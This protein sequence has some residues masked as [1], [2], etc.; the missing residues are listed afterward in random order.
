MTSLLKRI[1]DLIS[2]NLHAMI[3]QAEDPEKMV[4]EYL[5]QLQ[6]QLYEARTTVAAAMADEDK[7]HR[8]WTSNQALADEWQAK[9]EAALRAGKEDLAKQAL[10]R[11]R[12]FQQIADSYKAQYEAQD[13]QVEELQEAL[14]KLEARIAEARTRREII[15]AKKHQAETQEA[16]YRTVRTLGDSTTA[17]EG[18]ATMEER[19]DERLAR[20]R[21][22]AQ[23]QGGVAEAQLED[24]EAEAA[25]AEDLAE[26][27]KKLGLA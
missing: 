6:D 14:G 2:A 24:V 7:L 20:A 13:K 17:F 11:R 19:V 27:K 3:D 16:I 1:R 15:I 4:N 25:V 21:A 12:A 10:L 5:R 23:L 8:M 22:M 18:L 26:L 9:A